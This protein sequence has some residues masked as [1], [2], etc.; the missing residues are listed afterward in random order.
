MAAKVSALA[1]DQKGKRPIAREKIRWKSARQIPALSLQN[2]ERR[3]QG[4][5]ERRS[6]RSN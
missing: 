1:T 2:A 6:S 4:T 5:P 3:G